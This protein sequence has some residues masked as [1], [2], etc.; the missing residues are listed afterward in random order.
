MLNF[1]EFSM[2]K[3][4]KTDE[5]EHKMYTVLGGH[6]VYCV[7]KVYGFMTGR[8]AANPLAAVAAVN[9]PDKLAYGRTEGH[10]T[11]T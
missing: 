8:S 2:P 9:R 6:T 5:S 4:V 3:F 1:S 7:D 10:R 11:V